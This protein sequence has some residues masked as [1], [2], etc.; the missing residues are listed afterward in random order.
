MSSAQILAEHLFPCHVAVGLSWRNL[1]QALNG[2]TDTTNRVTSRSAGS[3]SAAETAPSSALILDD[4]LKKPGLWATL[5]LGTQKQNAG[6]VAQE[7]GLY[8]LDKKGNPR[9]QK[10]S[11][12]EIGGLILLDGTWAQAKTIWWR[13]AWL[14]KTKRMHLIPKSKSLYGKVRKEPRPECVS[15]LE[16]AAETLSFLGLPESIEKTLKEAFSAR[17]KTAKKSSTIPHSA[18]VQK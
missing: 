14:L 6:G 7:P 8:F 10:E 2:F 11:D 17:L 12:A 16:A 13:N 15:T 18:G 3:G 4:E 5:Y 1:E 9:D